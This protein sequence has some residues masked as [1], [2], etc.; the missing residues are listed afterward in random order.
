MLDWVKSHHLDLFYTEI[1]FDYS[2]LMAVTGGMTC[3]TGWKVITWTCFIQRYVLI[4][5]FWRQWLVEWHA[6]LG[7]KSS[8]GLVL[9]RDMFWLQFSDGSDWW[10]DMLDWVKSHHLDLFYTEICFDYS[11]LTAVTG[12]MTC[13][14]GWKVI[15]W[16][17]FK[18]RYVL[19][20]VFWRQWLVEWHAGLGEKSSPGGCDDWEDSRRLVWDPWSEQS[21]I[22]V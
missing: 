10:N 8:P 16:T 14:T 17:C 21:H 3:W 4:T 20:T 11:F 15:T 1:C 2:F 5:V 6:G 12:G 22:R 19:I 18:Q 13:W 7:E 9:Y